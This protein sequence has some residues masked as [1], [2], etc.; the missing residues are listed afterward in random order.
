[1]SG[2]GSGSGRHALRAWLK[3]AIQSG[4]LGRVPPRY[5]PD[6]SGVP[7][8]TEDYARGILAE[9]KDPESS[10][11]PLRDILA[12]A[13]R[14]RDWVE[15]RQKVSRR[16]ILGQWGTEGAAARV[17]EVRPSPRA[18]REKRPRAADL[19]EARP[20]SDPMWDDW[21]DG[22][23]RPGGRRDRDDS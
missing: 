1:M 7:R 18:G 20:R 23:T 14:F 19:D 10:G 6:G 8:P 16:M 3:L 2:N 22:G 5:D 13:R 17:P 9:L 4:V 11:R 12:D 21:L 15:Y